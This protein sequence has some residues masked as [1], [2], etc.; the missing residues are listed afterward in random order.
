MFIKAWNAYCK[1]ERIER[2]IV[3]DDE[4]LN[5]LEAPVDSYKTRYS[6]HLRLNPHDN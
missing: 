6:I 2:F 3:K 5:H 4:K 1:G